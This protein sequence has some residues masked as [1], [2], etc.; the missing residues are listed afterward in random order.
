M[1][2]RAAIDAIHADTDSRLAAVLTADE[3]DKLHAALP[4]RPHVPRGING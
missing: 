4:L 3:I 2:L 1:V